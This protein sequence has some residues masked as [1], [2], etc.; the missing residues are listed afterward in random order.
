MKQSQTD[1]QKRVSGLGIVVSHM[2]DLF[3]ER[4]LFCL[5]HHE[6]T[7]LD[8]EITCLLLHYDQTESR[9]ANARQPK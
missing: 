4:V 1:L 8:F 9:Q 5:S 7:Y 2:K 3:R 6:Y